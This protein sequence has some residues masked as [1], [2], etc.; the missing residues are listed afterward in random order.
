MGPMLDPTVE[1]RLT[2]AFIFYSDSAHGVIVGALRNPGKWGQ[3]SQGH[4]L[5]TAGD[6]KGRILALEVDG[7]PDVSSGAV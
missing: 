6:T 5:D 3:A 1:R 4:H 2:G 7:Q